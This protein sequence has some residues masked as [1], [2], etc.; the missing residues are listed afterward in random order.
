[1]LAR[2]SLNS[3]PQT[4]PSPFG[5]NFT[6]TRSH[7]TW[8]RQWLATHN[9]LRR[10]SGFRSLPNRATV[11]LAGCAGMGRVVHARASEAK[12]HNIQVPEVGSPISWPHFDGVGLFTQSNEL[13]G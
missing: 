13:T 3:R 6:R 4:A 9:S 12:G 8:R 5:C 1:M 2:I 10:R 7:R 11:R